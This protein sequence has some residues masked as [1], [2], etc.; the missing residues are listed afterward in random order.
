MARLNRRKRHCK[1]A[2]LA[3]QIAR[4]RKQEERREKPEMESEFSVQTDPELVMEED[5]PA[6]LRTATTEEQTTK[7]S[8]GG[9]APRQTI[10][11]DKNENPI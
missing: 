10:C 3:S 4:R 11:P 5:A 2:T 9:Q 6:Q 7:Y 1:A 8:R